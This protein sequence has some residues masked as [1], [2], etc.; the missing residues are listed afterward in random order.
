[1]ARRHISQREARAA[2]KRVDELE[3]QRNAQVRSW[4]SDYPGMHIASWSPEDWFYHTIKTARRLGRP[5]VVTHADG[6]KIHFYIA[7]S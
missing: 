6:G 2:L 4:T 7:K 5:V 1:M 3:E